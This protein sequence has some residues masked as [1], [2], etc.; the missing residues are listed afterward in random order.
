MGAVLYALTALPIV[1]L[2]LGGWWTSRAKAG[3]D[4][5]ERFV[6][7]AGAVIGATL[8][9]AVAVVAMAV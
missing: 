6:A 7:T 4:R 3:P 9:G 2:A 8:A 5:A 1:L